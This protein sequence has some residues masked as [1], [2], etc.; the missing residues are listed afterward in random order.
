MKVALC[1]LSLALAAPAFGAVPE[2]ANPQIDFAGHARLVADV[3]KERPKRLLSL[4]EFKAMAAKGVTILDARSAWAYKAGH[5]EGAVSLPLTD[6]TPEDVQQVLGDPK[7]PV[8]IY[9]NNNFKNRVRPV[10]LKSAPAA[11][12]IQTSVALA[13]YGYTNVWELG[14]VID[15]DD[16]AVGWV[17][18]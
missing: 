18:G 15:F 11:V 2:S 1:A 9:C 10:A 6:F 16:P 13:A 17:K 14:E 4:A 12:N 8:L 7:K 3:G 5:I